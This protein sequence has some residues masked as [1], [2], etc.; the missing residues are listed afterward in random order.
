MSLAQ[1]R[2][3]VVIDRFRANMIVAGGEPHQEDWWRRI[4]IGDKE[5]EIVKP[6]DH[7]CGVPNVNPKTGAWE[8][9]PMRTLATYRR[10]GRRIAFGQ[11]L[12]PV[13]QGRISVD[14]PVDV[15]ERGAQQPPLGSVASRHADH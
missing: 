14:Q 7:Q 5:F 6:C 11:N 1:E 12:V 10:Y 2:K 13:G 3:R 4:R 9:E 15:L 8:V